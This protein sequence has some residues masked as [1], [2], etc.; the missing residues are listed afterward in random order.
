MSSRGKLEETNLLSTDSFFK[1]KFVRMLNLYSNV[2]PRLS[3]TYLRNRRNSFYATSWFCICNILLIL[4]LK[5]SLFMIPKN[6]WALLG[7]TYMSLGYKDKGCAVFVLALNVAP[8][9]RFAIKNLVS[10]FFNEMERSEVEDRLFKLNCSKEEVCEALDDHAFWNLNHSDFGSYVES[11]MLD[12]H[13]DSGESGPEIRYLRGFETNMGHLACLYMYVNYFGRHGALRKV[14]IGSEKPANNFFL[15]LVRR[16]SKLSILS[17]DEYQGDFSG[18][19]TLLLQKSVDRNSFRVGPDAAFFGGHDF[20]DWSLEKSEE[21]NLYPN[22]IERGR[23]IFEPLLP[24]NRWL[25][26]LHIRGPRVYDRKQGQVRDANIVDYQSLC[27]HI[28][29]LGGIAIRMGDTRFPPFSHK[30]VVLDYAHSE[31]RSEFMDCWLWN[32]VA[33]WVGNSHGASIPPLLFGKPRLMTNQWYWNLIGGSND[34]VIPKVIINNGRVLSPKET[35]EHP[36]SRR[37]QWEYF[38]SS[39]LSIVDNAPNILANSVGEV[40]THAKFPKPPDPDKNSLVL[41]SA[42]QEAQQLSSLAPLMKPSRSFTEWYLNA[43]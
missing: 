10:H 32:E 12:G 24:G 35:I 42:I 25:A 33:F 43:M 1:I 23:K 26:A 29:D 7:S 30:G 13:S 19:D 9:R 5:I 18:T 22:E 3:Y 31:I 37:M 38:S 11:R 16:H 14:V 41:K 40:F 6:F 8:S 28:W 34:I 20:S 39:S 36:L 17:T 15:N 2:L 27:E 21:L 4:P